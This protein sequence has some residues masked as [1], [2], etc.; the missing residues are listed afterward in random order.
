MWY[1]FFM[2]IHFTYL[3]KLYIADSLLN[4]DL[5]KL[6][7]S[8]SKGVPGLCAILLS[9]NEHNQLDL[10]D[11]I[12]LHGCEYKHSKPTLVGIAGSK[13]EALELLCIIAK[14]SIEMTGSADMKEYIQC[15]L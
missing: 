14:D 3:P 2:K 15:Y 11:S 12:M 13:S 10:V 7:K 9:E 1:N 5:G 4:K 6:K 8:L